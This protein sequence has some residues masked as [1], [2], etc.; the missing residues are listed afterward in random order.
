MA[1]WGFEPR[2]SRPL[3]KLT[4]EEALTPGAFLPINWS[5]GCVF[6]PGFT[7]SNLVLRGKKMPQ[8]IL[9]QNVELD[10]K[11]VQSDDFSGYLCCFVKGDLER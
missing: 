2:S 11:V 5:H 4:P 3:S 10:A 7:G 8:I 6:P 9:E 1:E